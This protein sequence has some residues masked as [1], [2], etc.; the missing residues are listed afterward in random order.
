MIRRFAVV[1]LVLGLPAILVPGGVPTTEATSSFAS[2]ETHSA[3]A[4]AELANATGFVLPT[5][6]GQG[7]SQYL[8]LVFVANVPAGNG[9]AMAP[10]NPPNTLI[11]DP[12][13]D[14]ANPAVNVGN[15][16]ATTP[17]AADRANTVA[18]LQALR[19]QLR[20]LIRPD[21]DPNAAGSFATTLA[22]V[23]ARLRA[24]TVTRFNEL[25]AILDSNTATTAAKAAALAELVAL[26]DGLKDLLGDR[27]T[28]TGPNSG[29][30]LFDDVNRR[31]MAEAAARAEDLLDVLQDD[32][33]AADVKTAAV[34]ELLELRQALK[35]SGGTDGVTEGR[36]ENLLDRYLAAQVTA[37]TAV[38]DNAATSPADKIT[39]LNDLKKLRQQ[40]LQLATGTVAGGTGSTGIANSLGEIEKRIAADI[41]SQVNRLEQVLDSTTASATD[42]RDAVTTLIDLHEQLRNLIY[43]D[44]AWRNT[45]ATTLEDFLTRVNTR[46]YTELTK[47]FTELTRV[48]DGDTAT[49][50]ARNAALDDLI[51]L[52]ERLR[53]LGRTESDL[54]ESVE[55]KIGTTA[56]AEHQRLI[57]IVTGNGT[58]A[59]KTAAVTALAELRRKL[60]GLITAEPDGNGSA[61]YRSIIDNLDY[62]LDRDYLSGRMREL[63]EVLDDG[64]STEA[65]KTA[66]L[67]ELEGLRTLLIDMGGRP[68]NVGG[69]GRST[70]DRIDARLRAAALT[71]LQEL[72]QIL[73]STTATA[74]QKAQALI[75]LEELRNRLLTL[76]HEVDYF[77]VLDRID[78]LLEK[79][80][81]DKLRELEQ[82][83]DGTGG[84]GA[85][86]PTSS[87]AGGAST[88]ATLSLAD[89][90]GVLASS[91]GDLQ[92]F[93]MPGGP[94]FAA[95]AESTGS[96]TG[97]EAVSLTF[98]NNGGEFV[99]DGTGL[100][101]E[102]FPP[103]AAALD[104]GVWAAA[105]TQPHGLA[106][107]SGGGPMLNSIV[108]RQ[109]A[110]A[111]G[112]ELQ[113]VWERIV[114]RAGS[115]TSIT[116]EGYCLEKEVRPP[117]RGEFY[118]PAPPAKQR[119]FAD[120]RSILT[121]SATLHAAG[122]FNPEEASDPTRYYES[123]SQW[124]IWVLERG[125]DEA[126]F[127]REF[128]QHTRTNVEGAGFQWTADAEEEVSGWGPRRWQDIA[129]VVAEAGLAL[130]VGRD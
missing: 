30:T 84:G 113:E 33:A 120:A 50:A 48:L 114:A 49:A 36:I 87:A 65:Q 10:G 47:Q 46:L 92:R 7:R 123:I 67:T 14:P 102:P 2:P 39:A 103:T 129:N 40:L 80:L 112:V 15:A 76:S 25:K 116:P 19:A 86:G 115:V 52:H 37:L 42:K 34:D 130:P 21:R 41:Q 53:L 126:V 61:T 18:Q 74:A 66:A 124:S 58:A 62:R 70:V 6:A 128:V 100:V 32:S 107:A 91:L 31:V 93:G 109:N 75:D 35:D 121:A 117:S 83:L 57:R 17:N 79:G 13:A 111:S 1:L 122:R 54:F 101:L 43:A 11:N 8:V 94:S 27:I 81:Q 98:A 3:A 22:R 63:E 88:P 16:P 44:N 108:P 38:Y 78:N 4:L 73:E 55:N 60:Q 77:D 118:L 85:T 82:G 105:G 99:F 96:S 23:E 71:R 95:I 26:R 51:V 29:D 24:L 56:E 20:S 5:V 9:P 97:A 72:T 110:Q 90:P 119:E 89:N 125:Y 59:E 104:D 68:A 64:S 69:A 28:T 45:G 12:V 106:S 127:T